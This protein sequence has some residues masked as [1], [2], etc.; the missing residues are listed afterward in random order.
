MQA[1]NWGQ[2]PSA[3]SQCSYLLFLKHILSVELWLCVDQGYE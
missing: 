3:Q 2:W 1:P